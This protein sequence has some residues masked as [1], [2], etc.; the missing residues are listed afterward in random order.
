MYYFNLT[1]MLPSFLVFVNLIF[2]SSS[3]PSPLT[4][5]IHPSHS[6]TKPFKIITVQDLYIFPGPSLSINFS[7][8]SSTFP[9]VTRLK[10]LFSANYNQFD[11]M[12]RWV[13]FYPY[14]F[15]L[16][17]LPGLSHF[18]MLTLLVSFGFLC[19]LLTVYIF[20][21]PLFLSCVCI[22]KITQHLPSLLFVTTSLQFL[23][24]TYMCKQSC[25]Q[26]VT[27]LQLRLHWPEYGRP[28]C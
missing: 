12:T 9:F 19:L 28:W 6:K 10:Y 14:L 17:S 11:I 4:T 7:F 25:L 15:L 8:F 21:L 1:F 13:S 26:Y 3:T 2:P 24:R 5:P 23:Q 16:C 20:P 18:V 22:N 27:P